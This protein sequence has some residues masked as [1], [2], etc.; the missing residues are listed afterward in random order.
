MHI[1]NLFLTSLVLA[2]VGLCASTASSPLT[3]SLKFVSSVWGQV[4]H[5]IDAASPDTIEAY[6][7]VCDSDRIQQPNADRE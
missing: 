6:F 2:P 1:V 3:L 7:P 5:A 4:D